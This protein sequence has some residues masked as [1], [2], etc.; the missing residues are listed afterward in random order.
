MRTSVSRRKLLLAATAMPAGMAAACR[1][2]AAP[3]AASPSVAQKPQ[4]L[5]R[6]MVWG[7]AWSNAIDQKVI[8][9][10]MQR[11][12][13]IKVELINEGGNH[14]EKV[15][16][17]I[18]GGNPPETVM[19]DGYD[20]RGMASQGIMMDL[21]ARINKDIKKDEYF[22]PWFDEFIYRGRYYYFPNVRGGNAA[23]YYNKSLF[24]QYGLPLPR[25]GWTF[26]ELLQYARAIA[27]PEQGVW[28]TMR[29]TGLWWPF[30]WAFGGELIDL[31]QN[32]CL[33]DRPEAIE[34]IQW[35]ADLA[36]VHR[37]APLSLPSG[38]STQQLFINGRLGMYHNWFTDIPQYRD[39]IKDFEW[40]VVIMP[41]GKSGTQTGLY[42]GNGMMMP[43]NN[44]NPDAAWEWL[45]FQGS[46]EGML[47]YALE[48]RFIP[49]NK[50]AANDPRFLNSGKPPANMRAFIDQRVRTLPLI[51]EWR[52]IEREGWNESLKKVWDGSASAK[53][54]LPQAARRV[55]DILARRE[56]G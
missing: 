32:V 47:I 54:V 39:Q 10:F 34:A 17:M 41:I 31:N 38:V 20:V 5:V 6:Y 42:K 40:D 9:A 22:Q 25:E 2:G 16:S 35:I 24:E 51:P 52:Q 37:V 26:E 30:V 28:G 46:Y 12:P 19:I 23:Y 56:K 33:L 48:G 50:R 27:R 11:R 43:E 18:A 15:I 55:N 21:T 29:Q 53:E 7:N 45:K 4:G 49:F 3:G 14:L 44:K 1:L 36:H 8:D 13:E